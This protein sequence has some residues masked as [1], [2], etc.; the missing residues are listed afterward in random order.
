MLFLHI[1]KTAGTSFLLML[2]NT[3]GDNR[4]R[5]F[6]DVDEHIQQR[7]DEIIDADL[8]DT[9]S[10]CLAG[11]FPIHL[12]RPHLSRFQ[13]FTILRDPI[14]RVLSLYRFLKSGDPAEPERLGLSPNFSLAEFLSSS[15]PELYGQVR[16]GMV[17]MLCGDGHFSDAERS[18]FWEIETDTTALAAAV[19]N[20]DNM[21]FGLTE[22][23]DQ[24]L[25]LARSSWDIPYVL[26][27]YRENETSEETFPALSDVNRIVRLNML[28]IALYARARALFRHRC[29]ASNTRGTTNAYN[30]SSVFVPP[31]GEPVETGDIPGRQGFYE[32]EL[33][34]HIAWLHPDGPA[35]INFVAA[36]G[37]YKMSLYFYSIVK[38]YPA[39][40]VELH[41]NGWRCSH[42]AAALEDQWWRL[43]L[44]NIEI[45]QRFNRLT[46]GMPLC[47][48]ITQ[49]N[50][51]SRD[52][53]RVG[54]AL[55]NFLIELPVAA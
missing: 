20:L 44:D 37:R 17:R 38:E 6:R 10:S 55:A 15:N 47:I 50:P 7:L 16:N 46:I 18:E 43:C 54:L 21:D 30:S 8:D 36:P 41:L 25:A 23:M 26:R 12:F 33:N 48:P 27:E 39:T 34:E 2:Q 45:A 51:T 4:V 40:E 5:R 22:Q 29:G 9:S 52:R 13:I 49:L 53:R 24:S 32:F 19:A 28:D 35:E 1:P 42:T 3:F 31:I 14:E 11:H